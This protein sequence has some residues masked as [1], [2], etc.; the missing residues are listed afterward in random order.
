MMQLPAG[1]VTVCGNGWQW[2]KEGGKTTPAPDD[3]AALWLRRLADFA[4]AA[5]P[6]AATPFMAD[7]TKEEDAPANPLTTNDDIVTTFLKG[8]YVHVKHREGGMV[9]HVEVE[10]GVEAVT[11]IPPVTSPGRSEAAFELTGSEAEGLLMLSDAQRPKVE[12]RQE[13]EPPSQTAAEAAVFSLLDLRQGSVAAPPP[14][15]ARPP[16]HPAD[17]L[18]HPERDGHPARAAPSRRGSLKSSFGGAG[19]VKRRGIA[20]RA[21]QF[22]CR[23]PSCGKA[24]GCPDAVRK[25]C[26]KVHSEW[27]INLPSHGPTAYCSWEAGI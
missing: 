6:H 11:E 26:R 8:P 13:Q 22:R 23:Y 4:A 2:G 16:P 27:L 25:H 20:D 14:Q 19:T 21:T 7:E 5:T 24:Y 9:E 18:F 17:P 3:A 10:V 12:A 1:R 15:L